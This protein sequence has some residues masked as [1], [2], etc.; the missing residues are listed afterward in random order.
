M[1]EGTT[2]FSYH[3]FPNPL[4]TSNET[5][6]PS[7]IPPSTSLGTIVEKLMTKLK[8]LQSQSKSLATITNEKF[9]QRQRWMLTF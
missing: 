3:S 6:R 5:K 1:V 8:I 9:Y 4:L 7:F 2:S